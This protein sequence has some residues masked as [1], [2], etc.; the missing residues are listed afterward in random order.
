MKKK[1]YFCSLV[2]LFFSFSFC[3]GAYWNTKNYFPI[4]LLKKLK[5]YSSKYLQSPQLRNWNPIRESFKEKLKNIE[6]NEHLNA[7]GYASGTQLA[8]EVYQVLTYEKNSCSPG[9][10][11]YVS[12]HGTEAL[13][14][15]M[16]G[17]LLHQWKLPTQ[18][19]E[20]HFSEELNALE[21]RP[22][23]RRAYLYENGDLLA[24]ITGLCLVK[25]D[26]DSQVLWIYKDKVHHDLEVVNNKDIYILSSKFHPVSNFSGPVVEDFICILDQEGKEKERYSLIEAFKDSY[27]EYLLTPLYAQEGDIFHTNTLEV[28]KKIPTQNTRLFRENQILL[29]F[30]QIHT[31]GI[32][33]L[34]SKK[35]IWT[36]QGNWK[37]QHQPTLLENQHLLLFDNRGAMK[38][39]RIFEINPL[40]R[41]IYWEYSGS[42]QAPFR[43]DFAGSVQR[44]INGNTLIT[45]SDAGRC[46]EITETKKI[47]WEFI[48]PHRT[49]KNQELIASVF[50]MI[51]LPQEFPL[52][53]SQAKKEK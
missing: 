38:S 2:I 44:L 10:N 43:S 19:L 52:S 40:T 33:D 46:I 47:V 51:R 45:E 13:L 23:F 27:Y 50:E 3:L 5:K 14:I 34:I 20:Q 39:S 15:D 4:P 1:L 16:E 42:N 29:S 25:L 32:F 18:Y 41:E 8:P 30:R 31:I 36:Q 35:I 24:L 26:K 11:L 28:L 53:W 48:S 17:N 9:T 7:I 37:Y 6:L 22:Y 12:G 21:F 49:G